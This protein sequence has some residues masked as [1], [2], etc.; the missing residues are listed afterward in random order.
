MAMEA[1]DSQ[2][3]QRLLAH[4]VEAGELTTSQTSKVT[5]L[6]TDLC[7]SNE[8]HYRQIVGTFPTQHHGTSFLKAAEEVIGLGG[9]ED[10]FRVG[11]M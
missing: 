6:P 4:L 11:C 7:R 8:K 3:F 1:E 9:K 10:G 2:P 5:E